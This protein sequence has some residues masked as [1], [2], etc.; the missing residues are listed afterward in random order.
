MKAG[1]IAAICVIFVGASIAWIIVGA[2]VSERTTNSFRE[3]HNQV[4]GLWGSPLAQQAPGLS[5]QETEK[6]WET[7]DKGKRTQKTRYVYTALTPNSSDL[8]VSLDSDMRRKGLL[9]YRTYAVDFDATYTVTHNLRR[10]PHLV[11][12]FQFPSSQAMYDDFSFSIN[13]KESAGVPSDGS[14]I[15]TQIPLAPGQQATIRLHYKSRGLD[16]WTYQFANTGSDAVDYEYRDP[17]MGS[18]GQAV[19]EVKNFNLTVITNY[20][21]INF[22]PGSMSPTEMTREGEGWKLSWAFK[23]LITGFNVGVEMP[24]EPNA[25][26]MASRISYFAPVG[27]LFFMSVLVIIGALIKRNLHPMHYFF[28]GGGFFAFHLLMAYLA[29]HVE[30]RVTFAICAVVSVLLVVSYLWRAVGRDFTLKVAAP[31]QLLFLVIFSYTFF[32][33]GYTGLVITIAS[34]ITLAV[35]MHMTAKVDWDNIDNGSTSADPLKPPASP[36]PPV[37]PRP[38]APPVQPQSPSS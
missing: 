33:Q 17:G 36:K 18:A 19:A 34:I 35:L 38:P 25:G 6:Y 16:D 30:I 14:S 12:T 13:G 9:W 2:T 7:D 31:A 20:D 32:F 15:K 21:R 26:E 5:V 4:S 37:L 28:V 10:D 27:L 8:K 23:K 11:A 24:D 1:R 3:L 22:P 29:D